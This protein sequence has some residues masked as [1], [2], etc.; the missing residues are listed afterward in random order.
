MEGQIIGQSSN[1][2]GKGLEQK[3]EF[4]LLEGEIQKSII[5]ATPSIEFS[6]RIHQILIRDMENTVVLKLLGRNIGYSVLQNKI[7]SL[8]KPSSLFQLIDIENDYFLAKFQNKI[9]YEKVLAEGPWVLFG[10]YLIVQPW[11]VLTK[12]ILQVENSYRN[13]R[14]IGKVVKLDMNTDNRVRG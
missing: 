5:N 7:Y 13:R 3:E 9:D 11:S 4:E 6:N 12:I 8:W 1:I 10:Q 2:E 14:L